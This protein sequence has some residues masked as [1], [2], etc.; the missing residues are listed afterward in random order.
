MATAK[1]ASAPVSK[2]E[3]SL[4]EGFEERT[5]DIVGT[6]DPD[7]GPIRF[8]PSHASV[9]DG[10]K[11]DKTKPSL[12][13]FGKLTAP[14]VVVVKSEDDNQDAEKPTVL[15]KA[16]DLV[17]V[18][19]KPGMKDIANLCGVEVFMAR[20]PAKDRDTGKGEKM[21]AYTIGSKEQPNRII[22][23][24][25][26]RRDASKGVRCFLDPASYGRETAGE[27]PISGP[28]GRF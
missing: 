11:F 22:P 2:P 17:G 23:I 24:H 16:G 12:L 15:A 1:Q 4:P 21:K 19:A 5:T 27:V 9:G 20:N 8:I 6:W 7:R 26:D 10:K 14:C 3:P 13:I 18:W 28:N 25:H